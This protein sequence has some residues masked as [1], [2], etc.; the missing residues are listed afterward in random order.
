V[1]VDCVAGIRAL[2]SFSNFVAH[3]TSFL[4]VLFLHRDFAL[5]RHY[6][7]EAEAPPNLADNCV[8]FAN[9]G[10]TCP[11]ATCGSANARTTPTCFAIG[12]PGF[13]PFCR[14]AMPRIC[15]ICRLRMQSP[16]PGAPSSERNWLFQLYER[17]VRLVHISRESFT[18]TH[19]RKQMHE[20]HRRARTCGKRP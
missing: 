4:K 3:H 10:A 7:S 20:S 12:P 14:T 11:C 19:R 8:G 15:R 1:I 9:S 6:P 13:V 16:Q 5:E 2:Q 17:L 18:T